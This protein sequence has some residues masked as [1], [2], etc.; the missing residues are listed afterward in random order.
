MKL[1]FWQVLLLEVS[2]VRRF[3]SSATYPEAAHSK[4]KLS[5]RMQLYLTLVL[6]VYLPFLLF[7][8]NIVH[9][10]VR[11]KKIIEPSLWYLR[12]SGIQGYILIG[13]MVLIGLSCISS[14]LLDI[15][16]DGVV[17]VAGVGYFIYINVFAISYREICFRIRKRA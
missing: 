14:F 6:L 2:F 13:W 1:P 16:G 5:T 17:A 10:W 3:V 11:K 12:I 9:Y 7:G 4:G 15:I 8:V